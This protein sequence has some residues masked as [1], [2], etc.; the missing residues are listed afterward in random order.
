[1]KRQGFRGGS[2]FEPTGGWNQMQIPYVALARPISD[3]AAALKYSYKTVGDSLE[4]S[5]RFAFS[6]EGP[7]AGRT[8]VPQTPSAVAALADKDHGAGVEA[9][10][11]GIASIADTASAEVATGVPTN[12]R[13]VSFSTSQR[14][15]ASNAIAGLD[16]SGELP[17]ALHE[18]TPE[19]IV[20]SFNGT[21]AVNYNGWVHLGQTGSGPFLDTV[22][23]VQPDRD[24]AARGAWYLRHEI[25]HGVGQT[26]SGVQNPSYFPWRMTELEHQ[27]LNLNESSAEFAAR[28]PQRL[29]ETASSL[30]WSMV[31]T[32]SINRLLHVVSP[33]D[34]NIRELVKSRPEL[35]AIDRVDTA[36]LGALRTEVHDLGSRRVAEVAARRATADAQAPA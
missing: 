15:L 16:E 20:G 27:V 9:M 2:P 8:I 12:F 32:S 19:E 13:G 17:G 5:M 26:E 3:D 30:D 29:Q 14:D 35:Q 33:Y 11:R 28:D 18:V 6:G 34:Q 22:R 36:T 10:L 31:D 25:E 21:K 1:M 7:F 4:Q 23:G 24:D